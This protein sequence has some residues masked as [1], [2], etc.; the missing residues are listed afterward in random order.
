MNVKTYLGE[1]NPVRIFSYRR[2]L[3][4]IGIDFLPEESG[5]Y[6]ITNLKTNLVYIG[7]SINI[8]NRIISHH[9]YEYTNKNN[10]MY[11]SKFYKSLRKYGLE[12]FKVEV[13]E[14][15]KKEL[16]DER[17]IYWIKQYDSYHNGYNSTEGGKMLP[18]YT[19]ANSIKKKR[20]NTLSRNTS[21][22]G[23]KHPRAKLSNQEVINIRQRYKDGETCE[24]IYEDYKDIYTNY[25]T[26]KRIIFGKSYKY[27]GNI[28]K[29]EEI[30]YTNKNKTIGKIP[31][32]KII[33]I[34]KKYSEGNYTYSILSKEYKLSIST[35]GKIV[36]KQLYKNI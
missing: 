16:L 13:L 28:P 6:L 30:R 33:E 17:E 9:I 20:K 12:N 11:N 8:K 5:I 35:I 22:Q 21:L 10:T 3:F 24:F 36:N 34:R 15:C 2:C 25:P 4:I 27:V 19:N 23:E 1:V 18:F 7:Q 14:L 29:K 32:D 31:S 26:F